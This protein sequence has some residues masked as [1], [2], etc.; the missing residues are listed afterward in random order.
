M[1]LK[2]LSPLLP[3]EVKGRE[4]GNKSMIQPFGDRLIG[5]HRILKPLLLKAYYKQT[6]SLL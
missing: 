3:L 4:N 6:I 1:P 5:G 2:P